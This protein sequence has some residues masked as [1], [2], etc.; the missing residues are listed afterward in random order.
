M[1]TEKYA[2]NISKIR[3]PQDD[4]YYDEE[5]ENDTDDYQAQ[6]LSAV[7]STDMGRLENWIDKVYPKFL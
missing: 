5:D 7:Q 3:K 6:M 4:E 1:Q 2:A